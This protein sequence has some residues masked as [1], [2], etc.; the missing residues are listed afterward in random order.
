MRQSTES[1][2]RGEYALATGSAATYRLQVLQSLYGPG[3]RRALQQ[4]GIQRGMRVAD[5]GCGVGMMTALLAELVGPG[6]HAVGVDFS[7]AQLAQAREVLPSSLSNV[8]FVE[9]S[10][11]STGLPRESFDL[12]YCRYL[13][14]H[15]SEPDRALREMYD[16]LKPGGI[17]VCED[18]D[19]TS[20]GSEP[21]SSLNAFADLWGRLG[22]TKG[23]DYT[24][25]RRLVQ[26][27][28]TANFSDPNI[29]FNQPV[30]IRGENKRFLEWS[31]AEA[32]PAF[33]EA[34]LITSEELR[35]T[36]AEMQRVAEDET[37]IAVMPRMS[38][39]WARKLGPCLS[40]AA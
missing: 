29:T 3:S 14:L 18:G 30:A 31:V 16:I 20:A 24:L 11:T 10:A 8:S 34:G 13:L 26:M 33:V 19:L 36:L 4:A 39:I 37:V 9:A 27:A 23:V 38:Q 5:I 28:L 21:P 40:A 25:A 22:P 7:G 2:T 32:G 35:S 15:L 6:G 17:L 12:V 1:N